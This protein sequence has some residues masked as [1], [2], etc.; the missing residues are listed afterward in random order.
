MREHS[1]GATLLVQARECWQAGDWVALATVPVSA[2]Q[3][4]PDPGRLALMVGV[5]HLQLGNPVVARQFLQCAQDWKVDGRLVA[6]ALVAGLHDTLGRAALIQQDEARAQTHFTAALALA[7]PA[8]ANVS[9]V[10]ERIA[11]QRALPASP[12]RERMGKRSADPLAAASQSGSATSQARSTPPA[13]LVVAEPR[14]LGSLPLDAPLPAMLRLGEGD[15]VIAWVTADREVELRHLDAADVTVGAR[16]LQLEC[17]PRPQAGLLLA[18]DAQAR[19]LLLWINDEGRLF[20]RRSAE[21]DDPRPWSV[22]RECLVRLADADVSLLSAGRHGSPA[23]WLADARTSAVLRFD[24]SRA[25]WTETP[26]PAGWPETVTC[27]CLRLDPE[28]RVHLTALQP[29]AD[30]MPG[31]LWDAVHTSEYGGW[32]PAERR[33]LEVA[34]NDRIAGASA[35]AAPLGARLTPRGQ[36]GRLL[37]RDPL[38]RWWQIEADR[39]RQPVIPLEQVFQEPIAQD[40]RGRLIA[41]SADGRWW[42]GPADPPGRPTAEYRTPGTL[43]GWPVALQ[44]GPTAVLLTVTEP[45]QRHVVLAR[46]SC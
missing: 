28:G 25:A 23:V 45:P 29:Q 11:L 30:G 22:T 38:G 33:L 37:H 4:S 40:R 10:R 26:R 5:A 34:A 9:A 16:A 14:V 7:S 12:G 21:P 6:Q 13:P 17:R 3:H 19:L 43:S 24:E 31:V 1:G 35:T 42:F 44:D 20:W 41:R 36:T 15:T 32:H 39:P 46:L 18:Q 8:R 27:S 2:L